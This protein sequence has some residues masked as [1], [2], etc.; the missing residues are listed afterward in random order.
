MKVSIITVTYNS[1]KYIKDCIQSV[2]EQSYSDIEHIIIDGKSNDKTV[3][4]INSFPYHKTLKLLSES[5]EGIY[6]AMNKGLKLATGYIVGILNSDDFFNNKSI[7]QKIVSVFKNDKNIDALYGD[8]RFVQ[9]DNL[10]KTVRYYSGKMFF[11]WMFRFGFMP[12]HASFYTKRKLFET[13]GYYD[14]SYKIAGDL[15]LLIRFLYH[16]KLEYFYLNEDIVTMRTGGVSTKSFQSKYILN[17]ETIRACKNNGIYT[18]VL[19]LGLKY[20]IK[21]I[22]LLFYNCIN[23]K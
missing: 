3:E 20:I 14:T 11:P 9:P 23:K 18:N 2:N 22:Q 10:E 12:P 7:I 13:H 16:G 4:I 15:E 8:I 19:F 17:K 21:I 5:D 1:E 6:D